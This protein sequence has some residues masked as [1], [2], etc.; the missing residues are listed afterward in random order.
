MNGNGNDYSISRFSSRLCLSDL[1]HQS[2]LVLHCKIWSNI[3][4]SINLMN[5]IDQTI[6]VKVLINI[7]TILSAR[8]R[9]ILKT[10]TYHAIG[11]TLNI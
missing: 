11:F 1:H 2:L 8:R 7:L 10:L 4:S 9:S 6:G 5:I 3:I